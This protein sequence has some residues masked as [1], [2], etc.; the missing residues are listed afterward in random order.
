MTFLM[1]SILTEAFTTFATLIPIPCVERGENQRTAKL[2]VGMKNKITGQNASVAT[3]IAEEKSGKMLGSQL[4]R[5]PGQR[6]L[7]M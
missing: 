7:R 1:S 4:I 3:W 2:G 5:L 6:S